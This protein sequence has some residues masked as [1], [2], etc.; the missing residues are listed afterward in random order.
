MIK[1]KTRDW[2]ETCS[3]PLNGILKI[4]EDHSVVCRFPLKIN[5]FEME[6]GDEIEVSII[7]ACL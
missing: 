2:T 4:Y 5:K 1:N 3:P 6:S 7:T